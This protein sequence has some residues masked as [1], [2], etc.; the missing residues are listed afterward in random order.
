MRAVFDAHCDVLSK[1]MQ[2][3]LLS[4]EQEKG[5]LDVNLPALRQSRTMLQCFAVWLPST[6]P[7]PHIGHLLAG[8]DLFWESIVG[9]AG[10]RP[11]LTAVDVRQAL[12][13]GQQAAML[14]LEGAD[15]IEG[16]LS[17]VRT[18][19]RLGVRCL[20]ITWN[21]ANWAADGAAEPRGGGLTKKGK[22]LVKEC[23][24]LDMLVDVS[25]LCERSFWDTDETSEKPYI[26]S[27]SNVQELCD[28][29]RNLNKRQLERIG[30]RGGVVGINLYPPFLAAGGQ[31]TIEHV[32][33]H[34]ETA[35]EWAGERA[36]GLGS[37][38]DGIDI[39]VAGLED[40]SG[41]FRLEEMLS[42]RLT[43]EQVERVM[44]RNWYDFFVTYLPK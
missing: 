44:H 11:V 26:A 30:R 24:R 21:H 20:G 14:T 18:L 40:P 19:F 36:V 12:A 23:N 34:I 22:E 3:R 31:A 2:N 39:K 25:H 1:L 13:S 27:H 41:F 15:A 35:L 29:P 6:T 4:F 7:A 42:K 28:H 9:S 5:G 32:A 43:S 38:F 8:V 37:D 33:N 17:Y 10:M 16:N